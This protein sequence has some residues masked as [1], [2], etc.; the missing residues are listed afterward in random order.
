MLFFLDGTDVSDASL[1]GMRDWFWEEFWRVPERVSVPSAQQ[2]EV[3]SYANRIV[4]GVESNGEKIEEAIVQ[5]SENWGL[6]RMGRVD[7]NVLRIS[8]YELL[9][10]PEVPT[11]VVINEGIELAKLYGSDRSGGFVNGL[12]DRISRHVR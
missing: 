6:S 4:S 1:Q 2:K 3:R 9:H 5:S 10:E 11:R 12:L 8:T 7:R